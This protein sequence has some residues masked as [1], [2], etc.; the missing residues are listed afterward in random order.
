MHRRSTDNRQ[1]VFGYG[2]LLERREGGAWDGSRTAVCE[3]RGFRRTWN[4]AMDNAETIP[5][6]KVYL[7][8]RTGER[9]D[10]LVTFLNVV[11]DRR[12]SVNGLLFEVDDGALKDLDRRER[13]YERVEVTGRLDRAV[14]GT[15]WTYA[16][17]T[18]AVAR[19]ERGRRTGRALV[20]EEYLERVLADFAALGTEHRRR[21]LELTDDPPCPVVGLTRVDL[22]SGAAGNRLAPPPI[23]DLA[24]P[25]NADRRRSPL[26][27][28]G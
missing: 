15:V 17:R 20:S 10:W 11:A 1:H 28:R 2:S 23:P 7:D 3:L 18:A 25:R 22:P 6:Y 27:E 21:F 9:G 8:A 12:A 19:F 14:A 16:G 13:N 5:G 24:L 26:G 4:V